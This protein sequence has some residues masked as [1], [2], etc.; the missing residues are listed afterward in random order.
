MRQFSLILLF[1]IR[2]FLKAPVIFMMIIT[3]LSVAILSILITTGVLAGFEQMLISGAKGWLGDI[4]VIPQ[5]DKASLSHAEQMASEINT[6]EFVDAT[7]VRSGASGAIQYKEKISHPFSMI[8]LRTKDEAR[9]TGLPEKIIEGEF[10]DVSKDSNSIVLGL[11]LADSL[12]GGPYDGEK[13]PVGSDVEFLS[14]AGTVKTYRVKGIVD[15]KTFLPNWS[16]FVQKDELEK[17]DTDQKNSMIVIKLHDPDKI[18]EVRFSIQ[19]RFPETLV[20][21]W[22]EE[23]GYVDDILQTLRYIT[24]LITYLLI[25]SV[26]VIIAIVIF[27]NISQ[28]KRQIGIMKSMGA[29]VRFIVAIYMIEAIFYFIFSYSIGIALF[30]FVH[31]YSTTHPTSLLIGDFHTVFDWERVSLYFSLLLLASFGGAFVPTFLNARKKI[32]D[33]LRNV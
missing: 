24:L 17:I 11:N 21:T 10:L 16:V 19:E 1:V 32:I 6:L 13:I 30:S 26:F 15:A 22:R 14:R 27:I 2:D 28:K 29:T 3:S 12:I 7:S 31:A 8:G 25:F 5:N 18:G 23:S 9:V 4:V 33:A 20:H